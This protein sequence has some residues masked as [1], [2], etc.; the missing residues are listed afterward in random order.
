LD[1]V[2][3]IAGEITN[4]LE[5]AHFIRN[6]YI[7][8]TNSPW[9][10]KALIK[11]KKDYLD[12]KITI[13]EDDCFLYGRIY[14]LFLYIYDVLNPHFQYKPQIA[15]DE[16]KEP[17]MKERHNQIWSIHVD[18][19]M[20]RNGIETFYDKILRR[21]IFIDAEKEITWRE[22]GGIFQKLWEKDYFTYPEIT[23]YTY[24]FDKLKENHIQDTSHVSETEINRYLHEPYVQKHIEKLPSAGFRDSINELLNF[25]AYNCKDIYIESSYFGISFFYQKKV[26]FE[27]IPTIENILFLTIFNAV[28]NTYETS[29]INDDSNIKEIQAHIKEMYDKISMHSH[30]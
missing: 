23:D 24:N 10:E 26:V 19:R 7:E 28:S 5:I 1:D 8:N 25:T 20:E 11:R 9:N 4:S 22:A 29:I 13:W 2:N 16:Y 17:K 27:M 21:N 3:I 15:P 12:V 30:F 18:S 14:R 6:T